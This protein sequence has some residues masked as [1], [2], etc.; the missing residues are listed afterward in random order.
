MYKVYYLIK[1]QQ[2]FTLVFKVYKMKV[3]TKHQICTQRTI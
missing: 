1:F 3:V 2:H